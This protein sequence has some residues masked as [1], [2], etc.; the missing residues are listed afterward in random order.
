MSGAT[1]TLRFRRP[2]AEKSSPKPKKL[3]RHAGILQDQLR[4]SDRAPW[5]PSFSLAF[6]ILFLIRFAT[7]MY[8]NIDDCDEVYNFWE[9]LHFFDKGYGF[10]T[11]E[12]SPQYAIRSWAYILLH[13]FP[14]RLASLVFGD[15]KRPAFFALRITLAA[16]S[17]FAEVF[18]YRQVYEKVNNKVGRYLFFML[19]SSTGM[20][21]ASTA[22]LP[23]SFAMYMSTFAFA[24]SIVPS[25]SSN[26]YRT[27]AATI[28]FAAGAVIG[29]PFAL[30]LSLP[31][32]FEELFVFGADRVNASS[33]GN[34]MLARWKRLFGAGALAALIFI[35]VVGIDSLAYGK[36]AVV[37]WNIVEYNIFSDRGPNLYGTSPWNFYI[38]NL[39]LNFNVLLPFSLISLPALVITYFVD[40]KRLGLVRPTSEESSP[41]TLL[42]LRL[43]PF[44][45]WTTVLSLQEHKEERFMF[46]A[47]PLLCFNA[48]VALYLVRGWMEVIFIKATNSPYQASRSSIFR[49]FT[50][51]VV[52][53]SILISASRI[54]ALWYYYHAPLSLVY[55]LE[56]Q[57]LPRLLNDSGLLPTP[58]RPVSK[59]RG[60]TRETRIDLSPIKGFDLTLCIGKEWYRFPGHYLVPTGVRVDFVNS[61]FRGLLPGHFS[62]NQINSSFIWPRPQTRFT[63]RTMNDLNLEQPAH[64]ISVEQCDYLMDLDFPEN[65][66]SSTLEPR[67]ATL[68]DVWEK[69]ACRPFLDAAHSPL[70]GR[71]LWIPGETWRQMNSWGDYCLLKNRD[72]VENKIRKIRNEKNDNA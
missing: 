5:S 35:P 14:V 23:S 15:D 52:L 48:A 19:A 11:W 18:L 56:S 29:W 63:P 47:Y 7:A 58:S 60:E 38:S 43:L 17:T 59:Q 24:Y 1:Q 72:K 49:L 10:Q 21:N 71:V 50:T 62:E 45:L 46:P 64:Y 20:W 32:V 37:P 13:L 16:I 39:L 57:E 54:L 6:R 30:A 40:R 61:E 9:P 66:V 68:T 36:L 26:T 70:L 3:D 31:F 44:Y 67:Y 25:S 55:S 12:V 22:F 53:F 8:S 34:W 41:F 27:L 33:R 69:V 42:G 4:R 65:A 51:S 28:S 2:E